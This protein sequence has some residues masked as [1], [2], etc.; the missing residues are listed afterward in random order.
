MPPWE[1][2]EPRNRTRS[3]PVLAPDRDQD[4]ALARRNAPTFGV[5]PD[6]PTLL[7]SLRDF[8]SR[9]G[10]R[11]YALPVLVVITVLALMTAGGTK[12]PAGRSHPAPNAAGR[13]APPT[14]SGNI[15]LKSDQPGSGARDTVLA[16]EALPA[17]ADYTKVGAGTFHVL[18]GNGPAVG[19]GKV[20]R[21]AV[22]VEN[23]IS[24]IDLTQYARQVQTVLSDLRS[25]P[26]HGGVALQRVDAGVIDFHVTLVSSMTVRKLCGYD[27]PIET[28]CFAQTD[29][30]SGAPINRVVLNDAR[31]VRGDASYVGDLNAYRTY[32]INHED[33][34]ALGHQHAHQCLPGGLAPVMMQQTYGLKSAATGKLCQA[35]PWP[36]PAGTAGTPGAEQPDTP[37]NS[38]IQIKNN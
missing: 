33:G 18:P 7:R 34:H 32:L 28:S 21:Y 17:G 9:Y 6:D 19:A 16:A 27:I 22:E 11:A 38:E 2:D 10:W 26:G 4:V 1:D 20:R 31:W 25:W 29:P 3:A 23:G 5:R 30:A 14:A 35:N 12:Q 37:Q 36:F 24:G 8:T 13:P 15:A